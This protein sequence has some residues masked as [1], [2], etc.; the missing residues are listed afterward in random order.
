MP[1]SPSFLKLSKHPQALHPALGGAG[2][3]AYQPLLGLWLIDLALV[4]RWV[5]SPPSG[6]LRSTFCDDDFLRVTGLKGVRKLL[7]GDEDDDEEL[8]QL[9]RWLAALDLEDDDED[10]PLLPKAC[11]AAKRGKPAEKVQQAL[12]QLLLHRRKA[13]LKKPM[14]YRL[15]LFQ[16]IERAGR[17]LSLNDAERA[18]RWRPFRT[19]R[20]TL[21]CCATTCAMCCARACAAA[22]CC[23]TARLAAARPSWPRPW[24]PT[25]A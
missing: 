6:S 12:S 3:Q 10:V 15:P 24:P 17:L 5:E 1:A 21:P 4:G 16:N 22:M 25:W 20:K 14:D 13:L 11:H 9:D 7:S 2:L 18:A 23:C 8:R 19:W